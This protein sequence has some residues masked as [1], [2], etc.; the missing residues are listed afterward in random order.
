M[1]LDVYAVI[2][3]V[4]VILLNLIPDLTQHE[5]RAIAIKANGLRGSIAAPYGKQ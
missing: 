3:R 5:A 1:R 4:V 2:G